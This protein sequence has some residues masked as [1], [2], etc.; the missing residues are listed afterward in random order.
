MDRAESHDELGSRYPT[1][2]RTIEAIVAGLIRKRGYDSVIYELVWSVHNL[3]QISIADPE[4]TAKKREFSM[5]ANAVRSAILKHGD[6][7]VFETSVTNYD[8]LLLRQM[9]ITLE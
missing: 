2:E 3:G 9:G 8:N 4:N 6:D 7:T 5:W 1:H